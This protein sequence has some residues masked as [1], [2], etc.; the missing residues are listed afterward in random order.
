MSKTLADITENIK[1]LKAEKPKTEKLKNVKKKGYKKKGGNGGRRSNSGRKPLELDERRRSLKK[2]WENF[3][4]EEIE[5]SRLDRGTQEVRKD[6]VQRQRVAQE[7]LFEK[8]KE[9]DVAAIKEFNDR[10]L[11]KSK[12]PITGGDEDDAPL[13]LGVDINGIG[14]KMYGIE[15]PDEE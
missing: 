10:T 15:N 5:V 7:A 6:K 13:R 9:K 2:S 3:A 12:Q 8:V 4:L 11:G 1:A 14:E